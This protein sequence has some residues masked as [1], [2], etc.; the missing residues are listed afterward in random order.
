MSD[1]SYFDNLKESSELE[2]KLLNDHIEDARKLLQSYNLKVNDNNDILIEKDKNIRILFS[3][4]LINLRNQIN[5]INILNDVI[6]TNN[7]DIKKLSEGV[8]PY[9]YSD[10]KSSTDIFNKMLLFSNKNVSEIENIVINI[11]NIEKDICILRRNYEYIISK[12]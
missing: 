3:D 9:L 6:Y 2:D 10:C 4:I 12:I 11:N 7:L 5:N 8:K 1:N